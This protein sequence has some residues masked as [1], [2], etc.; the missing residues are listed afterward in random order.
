MVGDK[1]STNPKIIFNS[2][3]LRLDKRDQLKANFESVRSFREKRHGNPRDI[4]RALSAKTYNRPEFQRMIKDNAKKLFDVIIVWK[5]G[6]F[7]RNRYDGAHYKAVL[8][9]YG[10]KLKSAKS[11]LEAKVLQVEMLKPLLTQE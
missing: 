1:E 7:A 5:L 11:D 9:K 2:T 4:D 8:R 6:R 3:N 10:V